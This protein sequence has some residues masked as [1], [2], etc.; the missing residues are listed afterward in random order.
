MLFSRYMLLL[1]LEALAILLLLPLLPPWILPLFRK[2][3]T[4]YLGVLELTVYARTQSVQPSK[5]VG[6]A[7]TCELFPTAAAAATVDAEG[8][9]EE[10]AP[11]PLL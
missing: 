3:N 11:C 9:D 7:C 2:V 1:S 5:R 10:D 6:L 8:Y 4:E